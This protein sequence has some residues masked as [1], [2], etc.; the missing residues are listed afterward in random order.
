[1][2]RIRIISLIMM[3]AFVNYAV[4]QK[5]NTYDQF[6]KFEKLYKSGDLINAENCMLQVLKSEEFISGE[7]IVAAYNNLGA[8][9]TLL[10]KFDEALE[11]YNMAESQITERVLSN[12]SLAS[13]YVNK[14]IIF[15]Y[16]KSFDTAIEYFEKGIRI[17]KS[18]GDKNKNILHSISTAYLDIGIIYYKTMDYTSALKYFMESSE[19]KLRYSL[20]ETAFVFLNVAKTYVKLNDQ[21]RA[22]E[23]FIKSLRSFR[24]EFGNDY[25]RLAELYFDY[26]WFLE[27]QERVSEA[28]SIFEKAISIC[29]NTFGIKHTLVSLAFKHL[30]D[31]YMKSSDYNSALSNYQKAL[32]AV[33]SDFNNHD[34]FSNPSVTSSLYDIRLLD[35]LKSKSRAFEQLALLEKT[36][37]TKVKILKEGLETVELALILI[38]KI[39]NS[40][41]TEESRIYLAE[42]ERETYA[43]AVHLSDNLYTLTG[44]HDY[45]QNMYRIVR[46]A[47]AAVLRNEIT[48]NEIFYSIGI[49]D[50]LQKKRNYLQINIAAYNKLIQ[51]EMQKADHDISKIDFWKDA[52]FEMNRNKDKLEE[53]INIQFPNY[54]DILGRT[55]PVGL[56][57]I[58]SNLKKDETLIEYFF[59]D[60]DING[61]RK[62]YIFLIAKSELSFFETCLDSLFIK[63]L[64]MIRKG[65]V[66]DHL[67]EASF[68]KYKTYTSALYK[69]YK[70]L[71]KPVEVHLNGNK[72]IIIPDEELA[73]LPFSTFLKSPPDSL[74]INYEGLNYLLYHYAFSYSYSSSLIFNM[75]KMSK[76]VKVYAF[77][78]D[79]LNNKSDSVNRSDNLA[80]AK[81]EISAIYRWF[82]GR[83]FTGG[84]ATESN[85]KSVIRHPAILH[86]AMHSMSD[87][88]NSKYSCLLFDSR[89]DTIEDGRLFN[90]EIGA[91]RIMSP[92]VVLSACNTGT[93]TLSYGEGIM[94]LARGFILAGGS[95]VIKTFWDVNDESSAAI[96]KR[97]YYH[98]S[99]GE[100]KDE[101]LR[102]AKLDYIKIQ[103]PAYKNPF[104]WAAYDVLGNNSPIIQKNN[105][106]TVIISVFLILAAGV[107]LIYFRR[108]T[109]LSARSL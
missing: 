71:I 52:V 45:L 65:M 60:Q 39:R 42:N 100:R 69:M 83:S 96:M 34:I 23:Y 74:Q 11:Y 44:N 14:A 75:E 63:D 3:F 21:I 106:F 98:L 105:T 57:E 7:Y 79:Y 101:A 36:H 1:M 53:V 41:L 15:G 81:K 32:I 56:E 107:G 102:L 10:G 48:D 5:E 38:N 47:K 73:Y 51:D 9:K 76:K 89:K 2:K 22:E 6:L 35:I 86:L 68:E 17:Y 104:Y 67:N 88:D 16:R 37:D 18:A 26:G 84:Q 78:P 27:S 91:S 30:G 82:T 97:F 13:I 80:G 70:K 103:P 62:L 61:C 4:S 109:I 43:F 29:I 66:N 31:F 19:L 55:E 58:K 64:K 108:R 95:S 50:T 72:L 93:G 94:S 12:L 20:P 49:P 46:E 77:A 85:Y 33:V 28:I 25:Y 40:Y 99:K 87:P 90:Y 59:A 54:R 92:M 24:N 8:A